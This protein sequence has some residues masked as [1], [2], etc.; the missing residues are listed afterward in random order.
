[1]YSLYLGTPGAD[2]VQNVENMG[3]GQTV[4]PQVERNWKN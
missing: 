2:E 4:C 3:Y 1:M